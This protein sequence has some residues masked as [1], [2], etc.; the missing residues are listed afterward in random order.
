MY[1]SFPDWACTD[2]MVISNQVIKL[3]IFIQNISLMDNKWDHK[4]CQKI[5]F[6]SS[7]IVIY[8][9][10]LTVRHKQYDLGHCL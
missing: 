10:L 9:R 8:R 4:S 7:A 3:F 6:G 1:F 5:F 2:S